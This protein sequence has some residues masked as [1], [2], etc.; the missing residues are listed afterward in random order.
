MGRRE[1]P[2]V[3][4][5]APR[6]MPRKVVLTQA[7]VVRFAKSLGITGSDNLDDAERNCPTS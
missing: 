2:Q 4:R 5:T 6:D 1:V 7:R 3:T